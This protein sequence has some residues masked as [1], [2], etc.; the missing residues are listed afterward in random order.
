MAERTAT[1]RVKKAGRGYVGKLGSRRI[2][3]SGYH[4]TAGECMQAVDR[5]AR[6][7]HLRPAG[8]WERLGKRAADGA[9]RKYRGHDD[10][11]STVKKG[12]S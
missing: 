3:Q 1:G 11:F 2:P 6:S 12:G 7:A 8:K 4:D 10:V 5:L 9:V